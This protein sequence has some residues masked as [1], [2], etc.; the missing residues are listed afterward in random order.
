[1]INF[2][3]N[4]PI[5]LLVR[6]TAET[7]SARAAIG[8]SKQKNQGEKCESTR[9]QAKIGTNRYRGCKKVGQAKQEYLPR[10]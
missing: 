8:Y 4:L 9:T 1:M 2:V 3:N 10:T 5:G 7:E 6:S